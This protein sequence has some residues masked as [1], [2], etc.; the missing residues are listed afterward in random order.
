MTSD[1]PDRKTGS[2]ARTRAL[3]ILGAAAVGL[4]AL[5][6]FTIQLW[7][8]TPPEVVTYAVWV[9]AFLLVG[10]VV[11]IFAAGAY[12]FLNNTKLAS[13]RLP[14]ITAMVAESLFSATDLILGARSNTG[15]QVEGASVDEI[16]DR[17][18]ERIENTALARI[19]NGPD[20]DP[21][22]EA[23]AEALRESL[24]SDFVSEMEETYSPQIINSA[25]VT[26]SRLHFI[27]MR[28]R[29]DRE[30]ETLIRRAALNLVVGAST[31]LLAV[32]FLIYLVFSAEINTT[33]WE[34]A[35]PNIVLRLSLV[36]FIE[37]FAF[38]FLRL[39]R[40][41]L[42]EIKYFQNELTNVEMRAAA[43]DTAM[44]R[45][46]DDS[47]REALRACMYTERNPV[48]LAETGESRAARRESDREIVQ[49]L[50]DAIRSTANKATGGGDA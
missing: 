35:L 17:L 24:T 20:G 14:P 34:E 49:S 31:T 26:E 50:A 22:R 21:M 43:L 33:N 48:A 36:V 39:Y 47:I 41:T 6:A 29:L 9:F 44:M 16:V 45:G 28:Q 18:E 3:A 25:L 30:V 46:D 5:N 19:L 11:G 13:V 12:F 7:G 1:D 42:G 10:T 27:Q 37:I 8:E 15:G 32:V 38:F 40:Q 2:P 4:L 23:V